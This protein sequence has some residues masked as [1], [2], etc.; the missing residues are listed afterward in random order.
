MKLHKILFFIC[1]SIVFSA[2]VGNVDFDQAENIILE[3]EFKVAL[4]HFRATPDNFV[5]PVTNADLDFIS[6]ITEIHHFDSDTAQ[7]NIIK[8]ELLFEIENT[9]NREF[10][11]EYRFLNNLN[12]TTY[13]ITFNI[14][15]NSTLLPEPIEIVG[16]ELESFLSSKGIVVF[17]DMQTNT[18]PI[19]Q[20]MFLDYKSAADIF[21]RISADDN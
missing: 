4:V 11:L 5:D 7:E 20:D 9:F 18:A 3:P 17:A 19:T 14:P 2:C 1:L 21:L 8:I 10:N 13:T 12:Q 16:D 15:Q 6:D